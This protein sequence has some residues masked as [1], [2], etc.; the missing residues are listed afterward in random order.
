MTGTRTVDVLIIGAGV[1]GLSTVIKL[2]EAGIDDVLVLEKADRVGGTWVHNDYPGLTCDVPSELYQLGFAP[3]PSWSRTYAGQAEIRSYVEDV[4]R[5]FNVMDRIQL[6]TEMTAADWDEDARCWIV[7]TTTGDRISAKVFVPAPGFI[8]EAKMPS[9][10]GNDLFGG[11]MFH[12]GQWQHDHDFSGERVAVVGSGASAI[13][14]LPEIQPH[15]G[16]LFSFQRTPSWVLPKADYRTH[17]YVSKVFAR[18]PVVQKMIRAVGFFAFEGFY[19]ALL[20][21]EQVSR[22]LRP[23]QRAHI[24][25]WISDPMTVEALMPDHVFA[26]KRP[27]ISN[28]WFR[29]LAQPNVELVFQGIDRL[30]ATGVVAADGTEYQVDTV[31]FGTGYTAGD[32]MINHLIRNGEGKTVTQVWDGSPRSYL[33]IT[34]S[35]FPNMFMMLAPNAQNHQLSVIRTSEMQAGYI[36][37]AVKQTIFQGVSRFEVKPAVQR[38]FNDT[39]DRRLSRMA[40]QPKYCSTYYSDSTGRN[41]IVWPEWGFNVKRRL[42]K[43]NPSDYEIEVFR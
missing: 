28:K 33:G 4:A 9:F 21:P 39:I 6:K 2:K 15:V 18:F 37:D 41:H 23:M 43:F 17:P 16:R 30:T 36:T 35:G 19:P 10:P 25:R 26:C 38:A 27:M 24:E 32:L 8:G 13:Q 3:N 7:E 5:R 1:S 14:F 40:M 20:I 42:R 22:L 11:T 34:I 29:A 12:S 31:I